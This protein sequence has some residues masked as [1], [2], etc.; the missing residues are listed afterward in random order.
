MASLTATA[1]CRL[2]RNNSLPLVPAA[3]SPPDFLMPLHGNIKQRQ[4]SVLGRVPLCREPRVTHR[5]PGTARPQM[6]S[7][8]GGEVLPRAVS[9]LL[10]LLHLQERE[11]VSPKS[12]LSV[13]FRLIHED[14]TLC[15]FLLLSLHREAAHSRLARPPAIRHGMH[16]IGWRWRRRGGGVQRSSAQFT[17]PLT[18][19]H[20][21]YIFTSNTSRATQAPSPGHCGTLTAQTCTTAQARGPAH[22]CAP[23]PQPPPLGPP[24]PC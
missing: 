14:P 20:S 7:C 6:P 15:R 11:T 18:A 21:P 10:A 5:Q 24:P 4:L 19:E 9:R 23:P 3:P 1:G 13:L 17:P 22:S 8:V 2:A 16:L 12:H